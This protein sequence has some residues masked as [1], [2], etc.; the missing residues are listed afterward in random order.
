LLVGRRIWVVV[1]E[2]DGIGAHW[3]WCRVL[4]FVKFLP[5]GKIGEHEPK[6]RDGVRKKHLVKLWT[7][8]GGTRV[9]TVGSL[10]LKDPAKTGEV[11]RAARQTSDDFTTTREETEDDA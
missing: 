11:S 8:P 9:L 1:P 10:R 5:A 2:G 7:D 3:Y 6:S 4:S